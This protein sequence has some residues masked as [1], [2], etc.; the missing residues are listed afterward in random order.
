MIASQ[1]RESARVLTAA[2]RTSPQIAAAARLL[3][4]ACR[5]ESKVIVFGNGGSAAEAQHF[6][7]EL[8]G[9]FERNRPPVPALALSANSSD[10]TA[11]GNDFG[12]ENVFSRQLEAHARA[13]DVAV[14]ITTS[15]DSPNVLKAVSAARKL[16]LAAIGLT[17]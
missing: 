16:G 7:A 17:G 11:I 12:Y 5:R 3:L 8:V 9:R 14:A 10:L 1:L 6:A 15:G 4:E 2:V 13:G